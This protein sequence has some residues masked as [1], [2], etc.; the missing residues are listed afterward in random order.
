M[1]DYVPNL[2]LLRKIFDHWRA[3]PEQF[4][5]D[6]WASRDPDGNV[7]HC[8][9]GWAVALSP[10][11]HIAWYTPVKGVSAAEW[12]Y[13]RDGNHRLIRDLAEELLGLTY[14]EARRLFFGTDNFDEA[15]EFAQEIA[16]RAGE[17]L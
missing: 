17:R 10:E 15:Y 6:T 1:S 5:Q 14:D 12:V 11:C 7:T 9:A 8:V 13:D 2:A 16:A 4:D 3:H